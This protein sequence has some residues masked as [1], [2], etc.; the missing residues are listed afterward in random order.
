MHV[1]QL[2]AVSSWWWYRFIYDRSDGETSIV[3][4][5]IQKLC[6]WHPRWHHSEYGSPS[7]AAP[8]FVTT[9]AQGVYQLEFS[10][11]NL[12]VAYNPRYK[13]LKMLC[14]K[15][16]RSSNQLRG[17]AMRELVQLVRRPIDVTFSSSAG[18]SLIKDY[19]QG[20]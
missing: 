20:E 17:V 15:M 13:L 2:Y 12:Q 19:K 1:L 6:H 9:T 18:G 4:L 3:R 11:A 16:I 8:F 14:N 10:A 7:V 5:K